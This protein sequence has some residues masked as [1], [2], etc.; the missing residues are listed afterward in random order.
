MARLNTKNVIRFEEVFEPTLKEKL[1]IFLDSESVASYLTKALLAS[2][3]FGGIL[4]VGATAPNLFSALGKMG[5]G[6]KQKISKEGFN[7]IRRSFYNLRKNKLI[8]PIVSNNEEEIYQ[9][10]E[11][12]KEKLYKFVFD[13]LVIAKP[14]NWDRK[15][16]VVIFDIPHKRKV[17]RDALRRKLIDLGFYKLQ[18][19]VWI[20]PFPCVKEIMYVTDIFK[21]NAFVDIF[22]IDDFDNI[23]AL[24][25]FHNLLQDF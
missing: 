13:N 21:I 5:L 6:R 11:K 2:A 3:A 14:K 25:Y 10:T 17:A 24:N 15:W 1:R 7:K 23:K 19:S 12:G 8:Q 4:F 20:H 9:I 18:K 16:R 22:T